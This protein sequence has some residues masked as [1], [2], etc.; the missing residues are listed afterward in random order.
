[1]IDLHV[2]VH[3]LVKKREEKKIKEQQCEC[4]DA[5]EIFFREM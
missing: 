1:M 4:A 5:G 3:S 2:F